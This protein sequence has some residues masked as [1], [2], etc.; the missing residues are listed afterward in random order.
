M[1]AYPGCRIENY[2][3]SIVVHQHG[4]NRFQRSKAAKGDD[5]SILLLILQLILIV[6]CETQAGAGEKPTPRSVSSLQRCKVIGQWL[7]YSSSIPCIIMSTSPPHPP[8]QPPTP[9]PP[10]SAAAASVC[11]QVKRDE[12]SPAAAAGEM[13]V[14]RQM[15]LMA[16]QQALGFVS[17][18]RNKNKSTHHRVCS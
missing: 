6:A 9:A 14:Q 15:Q 7:Q 1:P 5:L 17:V 13:E 16:M 12:M 3:S 4:D 11:T 18:L 8:P 10:D 2:S